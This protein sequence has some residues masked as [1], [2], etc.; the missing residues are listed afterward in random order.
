MWALVTV[1]SRGVLRNLGDGNKAGPRLAI[2]PLL[3][4]LNHEV[5]PAAA[6]AADDV[7]KPLKAADSLS[8]RRVALQRERRSCGRTEPN[9]ITDCSLRRLRAPRRANPYEQAHVVLRAVRD[10]STDPLFDKRQKLLD[11]VT[12]L[13]QDWV[14]GRPPRM[15]FCMPGRPQLGGPTVIDGWIPVQT[16]VRARV[17]VLSD[18]SEIEPLLEAGPARRLLKGKALAQSARERDALKM[19]IDL[20]SRKLGTYP[21]GAALAADDPD[22]GR[23]RSRREWDGAARAADAHDPADP[24]R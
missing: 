22:E 6:P 16:L 9:R 12:E 7:A 19:L 4:I 24:A 20:A 2:V 18:S 23:P 15:V 13:Y 8:T 5:P 3:D 17:L 11:A 14:L 1:R 10:I 21:N